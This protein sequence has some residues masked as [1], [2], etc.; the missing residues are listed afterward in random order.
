MSVRHETIFD[1][2]GVCL[3][4]R[5]RQRLGE[6]KVIGAEGETHDAIKLR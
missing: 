5:I 4:L 2:S 1:G 3:H 6:N